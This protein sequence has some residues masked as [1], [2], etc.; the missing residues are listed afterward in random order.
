[1]L[2]LAKSPAELDEPVVPEPL[3]PPLT[4]LVLAPELLASVL[5]PVPE[6]VPAPPVPELLAVAEEPPG[7]GPE[8]L[9]PS[10]DVEIDEAGS[11]VDAERP[12]GLEDG[13]DVVVLE[14]EADEAQSTAATASVR[15]I[16]RRA[17]FAVITLTVLARAFAGKPRAPCLTCLTCGVGSEGYRLRTGRICSSPRARGEDAEP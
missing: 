2:Q 12:A 17:M 10:R 3:V 11:P 8:E 14:V 5:P 6:L 16:E 15:T 4:E 7:D 9:V 1:L 13:P